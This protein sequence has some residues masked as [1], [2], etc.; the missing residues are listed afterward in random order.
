MI[1]GRFYYS[2]IFLPEYHGSFSKSLK[3]FW[4]LDAWLLY[5]KSPVG[6]MFHLLFILLCFIIPGLAIGVTF[7]N[8][9][10]SSSTN[11]KGKF[12]KKKKG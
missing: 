11:S 2:L 5:I 1:I 4:N 9:K 3:I 6:F 7:F 10:I 12:K 8:D